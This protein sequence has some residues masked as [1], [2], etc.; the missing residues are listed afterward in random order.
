MSQRD[1]SV[2][3]LSLFPSLVCAGLRVKKVHK[4]VQHVP[5]AAIKS[6]NLRAVSPNL[7]ARMR[8][9]LSGPPRAV[10]LLQHF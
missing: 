4:R 3:Q 8:L 1:D 9:H 2:L 5:E 6:F 10:R 7:A